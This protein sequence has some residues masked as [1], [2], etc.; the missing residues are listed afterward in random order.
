MTVLGRM[1]NIVRGELPAARHRLEIARTYIALGNARRAS[2]ECDKIKKLS[3]AHQHWCIAE[4][5][6][7]QRRGSLVLPELDAAQT[8]LAD[9]VRLKVLRA[10]ALD[11][12]GQDAEAV[13]LL[14]GVLSS[15]PEDRDS[16]VLLAEILIGKKDTVGATT[17]LRSVL[18][19]FPHDGELRFLLAGLVPSAKER[20]Q[21]LREAT[22]L[23]ANYFDAQ[24][25][26]GLSMVALGEFQEAES[27]LKG[28][29][30]LQGNDP[31]LHAALA[32][33][34]VAQKKGDLALKAA[35]AALAL[36][37]NHAR[38]MLM[39]AEALAI[40]GDIDLAI[41]AYQSASAFARQEPA[42]LVRAALACLEHGRPSTG[43]AFAER[44]TAQFP[45]WGP[46][47]EV[48]G[49]IAVHQGDREDAKNA[50]KKALAAE[51]PVDKAALQKKLSALP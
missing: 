31:D 6:V 39:K 28:A 35:D 34:Y 27:T 42:P 25:A 38:G 47:W 16:A 44:A 49:D 5:Y 37:A 40:K 2:F 20:R 29:I 41:E 3:K 51:G 9:E 10:A 36:L 50:Y 21:L 11:I 19:R 13:A 7:A 32:Q 12:L 26:L 17:H 48:L 43:Y 22:E 14:E 4:T 45:K 18:G 30:Q 15:H 8:D 1:G 46:A 24:A 23:R 33:V